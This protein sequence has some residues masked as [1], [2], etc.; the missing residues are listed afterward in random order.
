MIP[1]EETVRIIGVLQFRQTSVAPFL[2]S[3]NSRHRFVTV[4]IVLVNLELVVAGNCGLSKPVA[5]IAEKAVHCICHRVIGVPSNRLYLVAKVM[6]VRKGGVVV[7]KC[8]DTLDGERLDLQGGSVGRRVV[9]HELLKSV[10]E[11]HE[12]LWVQSP[13]DQAVKIVSW[14]VGARR[15][16]ET[17]NCFRG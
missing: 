13:G 16:Y 14:S 12:G 5:P 4:T 2:I 9:L 17:E 10:A 6:A 15:G 3:V 1:I 7:W 11:I 8:H